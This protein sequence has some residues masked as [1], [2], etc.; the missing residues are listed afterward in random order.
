MCSCLR[1]FWPFALMLAVFTLDLLSKEWILAFFRAG[2]LP[3]EMTS[4]FHLALVFNRGATFG[5]LNNGSVTVFWGLTA[6]VAVVIGFLVRWLLREQSPFTRTA[7]ALIIGG[8]LG[9]L[10][11]RLF[12]GAVVDFL[13]FFWH[14]YHWPAFNVADTS[15]VIGVILLTLKTVKER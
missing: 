2:R 7:L 4:F 14:D 11:D 12:R 15:I 3:V 6:I 9:N 5:L 1:R 8:A 10:Y 13:D